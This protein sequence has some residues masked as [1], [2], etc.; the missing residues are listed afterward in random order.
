M[1]GEGLIR[2][3]DCGPQPVSWEIGSL[4]SSC[5][6]ERAVHARAFDGFLLTPFQH[7]AH[8]RWGVA[9]GGYIR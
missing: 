5:G 8:E 2:C 4:V 7:L 6:E 1:S 9:S 3:V